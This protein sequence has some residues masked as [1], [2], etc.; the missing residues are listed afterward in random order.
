MP[1]PPIFGEY[2]LG[3]APELRYTPGG[4]AVCNM[5]AVAGSRKQDPNTKEWTDDK[6][7]WVN[8]TVFG[9]PA[10]NV[11]ESDLQKGMK[12]LVVGRLHVQQYDK[13]DGTKGT[14]VDVLCD[15]IGPSLTFATARVTKVSGGGGG[16][17]SGGSEQSRTTRTSSPP[18][19]DPWATG[20]SDEP[21]F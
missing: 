17:Q 10:E 19:D 3:S 2:T 5:R 9:K 13:Q 16:Q 14:S 6:Q 7:S 21:P 15:A 18:A 1:L 4:M 20:P 8:L 12:V 11:A